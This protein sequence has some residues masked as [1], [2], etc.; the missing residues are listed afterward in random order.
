[1][2]KLRR[3]FVLIVAVFTVW[4][5]SLVLSAG[6]LPQ[7]TTTAQLTGNPDYKTNC[8]K[9]HGS[10]ATGRHFAG[11]SLA[12]EKVTGAPAA[13]LTGIISKGKGRMPAFSGKLTA[14]QINALVLEIKALQ[15]GAAKK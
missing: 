10:K 9:C 15:G 12:S 3:R 1:M 11:P 8:A 5:A 13:E 2:K 7:A 6:A 4:C 14:D